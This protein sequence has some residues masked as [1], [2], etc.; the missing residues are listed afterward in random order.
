MILHIENLGAIKQAQIDLTNKFLLL[1][2]KNNTGK[3]YASYILYAFL[4]DKGIPSTS[5]GCIDEVVTQIKLEGIITLKRDYIEE[6]LQDNCNRV[7]GALGSIFG[8]ADAIKSKLFNG[9]DLRAEYTDSD[10]D[11]AIA[12]TVSARFASDDYSVVVK[13]DAGNATAKVEVQS[14]TGQSMELDYGRIQTLVY[15]LLRKLALGGM[16]DAWMLTVERNSIYTFKTELSLSRNEL[17]DHIQ[18]SEGS[19][20]NIIDMI[21]KSSRRYPMAIRSSLRIANDLENVQKYVGDYSSIADLIERDL[22]NGEV[23]MTKNG[24]VEF[25]SVGMGKSRRLPFHMSSSIVKTMA[26]LVVYLRHVARRGDMLIIDEPEMNF[27]PDV[28]VLLARI[29]V[30][31]TAKGLRVVLSTHSDYI[32]RELNNLIMAGTIRKSGNEGIAK[33]MGYMDDMLLD[34]ND[35]AVMLFEQT[36][37]GKVKVRQLVVDDKGFAVESIDRTIDRQNEDAEAL[38]AMLIDNE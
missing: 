32:I 6:W 22:L 20:I 13:K 9:F 18:Q 5:L 7:K 8:V 15:A 34:H 3:T 36:G 28:Q 30:L 16:S 17:I 27:H 35:I 11:R 33:E 2:G 14:T 25:H 31:L 10:F 21:N 23:S 24:D 1:C 4:S 26:S 29:F 12:A 19:E 38:Y 37:N